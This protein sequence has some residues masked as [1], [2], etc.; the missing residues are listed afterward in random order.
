MS[1]LDAAYRPLVDWEDELL[2]AINPA[3]DHRRWLRRLGDEE[4]H[5]ERLALWRIEANAGE[6]LPVF[7]GRWG[8]AEGL[9]V[10][11][12]FLACLGRAR[13]LVEAEER[14]R[15]RA[16]ARGVPR[17]DPGRWVPEEVIAAIREA[18][19]LVDVIRRWGLT[20]LRESPRG[21][22][23]WAGLCPFHAERTPSFYV[24]DGGDD[25]H[26]HCFGCGAHGDVFDL[27]RE[28]AAWT[29]FR[30]RAEGLAGLVGIA[31]PPAADRPTIG[32]RVPDYL[33]EV[34]GA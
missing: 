14:W 15:E 30:E 32:R 26:F 34:R 25:P 33:G 4:L 31:W 19:S 28:H 13:G 23:R 27:A 17:L 29:S 7:L 20:A 12:T 18:V 2:D 5:R 6:L 21:S 8:E 9:G 1:A 10:F 22:G 24:Y 11:I 3:R 16:R